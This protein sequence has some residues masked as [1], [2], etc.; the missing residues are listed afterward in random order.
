LSQQCRDH[1]LA[2]GRLLGFGQLSH[3]W[4]DFCVIAVGFVKLPHPEK[5][6]AGEAAQTRLGDGDVAGK[7]HNHALAPFSAG[8]FP[9]QVLAN[10]PVEVDEGGVD[11]LVG[12]LAGGGDEIEDLAEVRNWC[13]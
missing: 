5:V 13:G 7:F 8:D 11:C 4:C 10:L 9:A 3:Q 12:S 1:F 2:S 6:G